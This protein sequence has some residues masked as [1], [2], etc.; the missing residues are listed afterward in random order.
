MAEY[1]ES[2][3]IAVKPGERVPLIIRNKCTSPVSV[4]TGIVF[5]EDGVY[6][7]CVDGNKIIVSKDAGRIH[8]AD[9]RPVV[10]GKWTLYGR[11]GIYGVMYECSICHAKYDGRTNFCPHCGAMMEER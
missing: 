11:R 7:V 9:V 10:R 5:R 4:A 3:P 2:D 8:A 1:C 6:S